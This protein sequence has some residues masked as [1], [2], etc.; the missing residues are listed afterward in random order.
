MA[1]PWDVGGAHV[2][3]DTVDLLEEPG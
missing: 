2:T 3:T 1:P